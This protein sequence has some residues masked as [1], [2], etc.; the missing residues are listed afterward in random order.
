MNNQLY[1]TMEIKKRTVLDA[2][3][4]NEGNI[5]FIIAVR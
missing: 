1:V 4:K 2:I 3:Q 5:N